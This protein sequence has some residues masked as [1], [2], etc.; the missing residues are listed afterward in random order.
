MVKCVCETEEKVMCCLN[1]DERSMNLTCFVSM[2]RLPSNP[3][4]DRE[5]AAI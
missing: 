5:H 4:S 1:R 3:Y 2:Y